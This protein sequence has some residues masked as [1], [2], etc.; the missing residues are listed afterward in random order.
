ME[1]YYSFLLDYYQ[2]YAYNIRKCVKYY[3]KIFSGD[4]IM[5][6]VLT[7]IIS[8][9]AAFVLCVCVVA[10][11]GGVEGTYKFS[12]MSVIT[13][14]VNVDISVGEKFMGVSLTEDAFVLT[15]NDD[16]TFELVINMGETNGVSGTWELKDGKY[17]LLAEGNS[18]EVVFQGN[19]AVFDMEGTKLE[20]RK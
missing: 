12:K 19:T 8:A 7:V 5:K 9:I 18:I 13:G 17:Y 2:N 15:V 4:K 3:T 14:G 1:K 20:L 10:C 16:N 11:S 6:K